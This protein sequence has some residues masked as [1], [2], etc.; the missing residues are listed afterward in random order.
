MKLNYYGTEV[1][2]LCTFINSTTVNTNVNFWAFM[3]LSEPVY[4]SFFTNSN[5]R[6]F[7][8][9]TVNSIPNT[10]NHTLSCSK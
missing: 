1:I 2:L 6:W 3:Q 4:C 9:L 7:L 10:L 8:S 5:L